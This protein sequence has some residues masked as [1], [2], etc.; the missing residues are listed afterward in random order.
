MR[1]SASMSFDK[2]SPIRAMCMTVA[3]IFEKLTVIYIYVYIYVIYIYDENDSH[4][5]TL[6]DTQGNNKNIIALT[7]NDLF[8]YIMTFPVTKITFPQ[9]L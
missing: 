4:D 1:Q 6:A 2:G 7:N 5:K 9:R 8:Q 3:S